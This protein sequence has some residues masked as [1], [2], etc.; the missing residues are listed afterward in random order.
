MP[1]KPKKAS[2]LAPPASPFP[3]PGSGPPTQ[4]GT[5]GSGQSYS[6]RA[7]KGRKEF[8]LWL[9][10]DRVTKLDSIK[11]RLGLKSTKEV[12]ERAVDEMFLRYVQSG[13]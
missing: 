10:G 7:A 1:P 9:D 6:E 4:P 11:S 5:P 12:F 3:A 2:A 8:S 13:R